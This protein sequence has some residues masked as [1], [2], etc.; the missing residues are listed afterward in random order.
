MAYAAGDTILDDE[1]NG[2]AN[3]SSNNINAIWGNGNGN[4]GWGQSNTISTVSAG[5]TITAAQWNT[6]QDRL[7]SAADHQGSTINNSGGS[8]S[9]G[10]TIAIVSNLAADITTITNNR[11]NVDS[12]HLDTTNDPNSV[13]R[14][15]TSVWDTQVIHEVSFTFDSSDALRYFFQRLRDEVHR[16]VIG[17]HRQK[18][19]KSIISTRLDEIDGLGGVRR[20][21]LLMKFGSTKEVSRASVKELETVQGISTNLA[22][23]IYNYSNNHN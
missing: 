12:D 18:R 14:T 15:F 2:F 17:A 8:L 23:Q 11:Y 13:N 1:Y 20:N 3:S 22:E 10:N 16:F 6:L 5:A 9:A 19:S 7:K 4:K 21:N